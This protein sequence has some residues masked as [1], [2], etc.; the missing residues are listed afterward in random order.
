MFISLRKA[1]TI[2][3]ASGFANFVPV[4]LLRTCG[5]RV[6]AARMHG[7]LGLTGAA[8]PAFLTFSPYLIVCFDNPPTRWRA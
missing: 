1:V 8:Q 2:A 5:R 6:P 7:V 3:Q 4:C